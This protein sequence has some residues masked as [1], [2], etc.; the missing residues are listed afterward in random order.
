MSLVT[1][2][3]LPNNGDRIKVENYNDPIT[4]I[5]AVLNGGIDGTNITTGTLPWESMASFTN[6][7]PAAAMQDSGNLDKFRSESAIGFIASGMVW[8]TLSGL[9]GTMTTGILYSPVSG[10]RL[11]VAAIASKT[12]TASQD[13]YV[14]VSDAGV[15]TY[16]AV[17]N[18]AAQPALTSGYRW[19]AKVVTSGAAITSITDLR[20]T[21]PIT[22]ANLDRAAITLGYASI[23]SNFSSTT[24]NAYTDVTNLTTTVVIPPG[25][26]RIKITAIGWYMTTSA[27]AGTNVELVV[28]D[29]TA[30]AIVGGILVNN[31]AAFYAMNAC[32]VATH[33]P[34]AGTRTYKVQ[35]RSNVAGTFNLT[36]SATQPAYILVE[37]I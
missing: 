24:I 27:A 5:L 13:T 33:V 9:N 4:K 3:V 34:A 29:V 14:S 7:I 26:R 25:A 36:A 12:F 16:Q 8:S 1:G 18:G 28:T 2:V 31:P 11:S 17:A 10:T 21:A 23:T 22:A 19:L 15:V 6:K 37:A 20:Q 30:G 35:F 32:T